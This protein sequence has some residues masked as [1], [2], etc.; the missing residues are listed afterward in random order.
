MSAG[1][2]LYKPFNAANDINANNGVTNNAGTLQL[3][4]ALIQNTAISG[5]FSLSLTDAAASVTV[6]A[7]GSSTHKIYGYNA[8]NAPV[9]GSAAGLFQT[10]STPAADI[11][12][13]TNIYGSAGTLDLNLSAASVLTA[14]SVNIAGHL[15]SLVLRSSVAQSTGI[16]SASRAAVLLYDAVN[17]TDVR[18]FEVKSPEVSG[19]GAAITNLSGLYVAAQKIAAVTNAYGIYQAGT[20]DANLFNGSMEVGQAFLARQTATV[21]GSVSIG[22]TPLL[23]IARVFVTGDGSTNPV[24]RLQA[25][26]LENEVLQMRNNGGALVASFAQSGALTTAAPAGGGAAAW[27]FG[28]TQGAD[29]TGATRYIQIQ[30][31]AETII[32]IGK[33]L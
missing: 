27:L 14:A 9:N 26:G 31:G 23:N 32:L 11:T 21:L 29:G 6:G 7:T 2:R 24:M 1:I 33:V 18:S 20:Q 22:A 30:V 15:S 5:A 19:S 16:L 25:T 10:V 3:G 13:I 28:T 12:G 8:T 17:A 4:G